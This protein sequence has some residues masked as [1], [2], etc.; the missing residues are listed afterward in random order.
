M[1]HIR[2]LYRPMKNSLRFW[3]GISAFLLAGAALVAI[4]MWT[5]QGAPPVRWT[6][7]PGHRSF[8][9]GF[10]LGFIAFYLCVFL[11]R[12]GLA[13]FRAH[14]KGAF[15]N[16]RFLIYLAAAVALVFG[17][18]SL[19]I[20]VAPDAGSTFPQS[21]WW[22]IAKEP[23][24]FF[25]IITGLP[26]LCFVALAVQQLREIRRTVSSFSE[27]ID[28]ICDLAD[29]ATNANPVRILAYTPAVGY[30]A[31][32][33]AEWEQFQAAIN[34]KDPNGGPIAEIIC[35]EEPALQT[36]HNLF[37]GRETS[38]GTL[39]SEM[40]KE[41]SRLA[42][43]L[44]QQL[45]SGRR[46]KPCETV[47]RLPLDFMPGYYFFFTKDRAIIVVP[48]FLPLPNSAPQLKQERLPTVQMIGFETSERAL[49]QDVEGMYDY[50]KSLSKTMD[51]KNPSMHLV[52][53]VS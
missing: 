23:G 36:W 33:D 13:E 19:A 22:R 46:Y 39:D 26:T 11:A 29:K 7:H 9:F 51:G 37:A 18:I 31:R 49:V 28:R 41:A 21:L 52:E 53:R 3:P 42:E 27:L 38:R 45:Q 15:M 43:G 32:P 5:G 24:G 2:Q 16:R 44:L 8:W 35:L 20:V 25:I 48:L 12:K 1:P 6:P 17:S 40:T 34:R 10:F 14:A 50:Y 30:L 47:H 4:S